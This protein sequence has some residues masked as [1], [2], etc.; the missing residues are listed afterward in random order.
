M[1][2]LLFITYHFPPT[3]GSGVQRGLKFAK[4]LP[5][6]GFRPIVLC[7][8][9]RCL[10][11]QGLYFAKRITPSVKIYRTFTLDANWFLSCCGD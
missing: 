2:N 5:Q 9:Y 6:F 8:D 11:T 10:N 4:Y 7:A 1:K 3:G